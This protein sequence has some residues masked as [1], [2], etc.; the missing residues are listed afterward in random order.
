MVN[1]PESQAVIKVS[2]HLLEALCLRSRPVCSRLAA[3]HHTQVNGDVRNRKGIQNYTKVRRSA[4]SW[5]SSWSSVLT[6]DI[7]AQ[8]WNEDSAQDTA[9]HTEERKE[10]YSDVINGYYDGV[11]LL[12]YFCKLARAIS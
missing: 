10:K 8:F 6:P 11:R 9:A 7:A 4:L 2:C 12:P 1:A 5:P 3:Q